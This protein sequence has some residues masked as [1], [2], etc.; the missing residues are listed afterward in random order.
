MVPRVKAEQVAE[1]ARWMC[2]DDEVRLGQ[3]QDGIGKRRDGTVQGRTGSCPSQKLRPSR[4][5][6][7]SVHS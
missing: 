5:R 3:V 6:D 7:L 2:E 4:D 1:A